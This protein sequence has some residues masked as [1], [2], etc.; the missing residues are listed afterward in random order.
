MPLSTVPMLFILAGLIFYVV[1]GGADFG[2]ALWQISAPRKS[3]P[4]TRALR[5]L[6]HDVMSP[7]WEANH[8]WLIFVLTV[9]WTA[10]PGAL[11]SIAS[12][13]SIALSV[14]AFGIITRGAAYATS[15]G[16]SDPRELVRIDTLSAIASVLAPFALGA[17]VGAIAS[18]RVPYGNARGNLW[19]SWLN[20]TSILI[21]VL[22]VV[23]SAY[24]AAVYLC[25]DAHRRGHDELVAPF[26]RRAI[27]AGLVAGA[28]ALAGLI[29]LHSD[30]HALY[31]QLVSGRGLPAL[32]VSVVA[33]AGTLGLVVAGR[34]E[35]ARF[36]A[37]LAVTAI[38]VGWALAQEPRFLPGLTV[39]EA[40]ASH[41]TLVAVI[42]AVVGGGI[43]LFPALGLLLRLTLGGT[44]GHHGEMDHG[45]AGA[46]GAVAALRP[47]RVAPP[48]P[49][50]SAA[51]VAV[52]LLVAGFGLLN[53]ADARWAHAIGVV[54]LIGAV[55]V[56]FLAA[57]P[58][59]L[60]PEGG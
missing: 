6:A 41:D 14:A 50:P 32:I 31:H 57:V 26:Q 15:S 19:T 34:Y 21:G 16:T 27:G 3:D 58:A 2:A 29:V 56:G 43:L 59:W 7:V 8:V 4:R 17:C 42:V 52:A 47:G 54:C 55:V 45:P 53:V 33:G 24:L 1:L 37:A 25:A 44:L 35:P 60:A 36:T 13:L 39:S 38:V 10:Y 40:A 9:T 49:T 23:F 11:G 22:A 5:T 18:G 51:R 48:F 20:P 30:A 12:T 46:E 28:L